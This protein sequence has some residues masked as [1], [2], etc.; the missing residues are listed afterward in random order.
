MKAIKSVFVAA[1]T[2]VVLMLT[3]CMGDGNNERSLEGFGVISSLNYTTPVLYYMDYDLPLSGSGLNNYALLSE[4]KYVYYYFTVDATDENNVDAA[5]RGYYLA[6]IQI[7]QEFPVVNAS[8]YY[9]YPGDNTTNSN[10]ISLAGVKIGTYLKESLFLAPIIAEYPNKASLSYNLTFDATQEITTDNT[11]NNISIYDLYITATMSGDEGTVVKN[12]EDI[13][14]FKLSNGI[15]SI[16]NTEKA[17]NK[18]SVY[19]RINYVEKISE[20]GERTWKAHESSSYIQ[21][22]VPSSSN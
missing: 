18:T 15:N 17:K 9:G 4:D 2:A 10:E 1:L 22:P 6:N 16:F 19:F 21:L 8:G 3:S 11:L 13:N 7:I 5:T 20:D 14:A 12:Q